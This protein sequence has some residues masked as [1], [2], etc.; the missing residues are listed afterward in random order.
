MKSHYRAVIIG[1]GVI[2]ASVAY[3]LTKLG[4]TDIA[5][6]ERSVLT[7]GSSWHAA[8]GVHTLNADPNVAALQSYTIDLMHEIEKESGQSVGLHM[9]G[10]LMLARAPD[11]WEWLQSNCRVLQSMGIDDAW[12]ATPDEL[13]AQ[14]SLLNTSDLLG[15]MVFANEGYVDPSG[16]VHAYAKCAKNRGAD[17]IEHNRVLSLRQRPDMSWEVTTEKGVIIA[18]HVVNAGGL[19]AKQ[20]GRMV[21]VELPVSPME[22]HYLV[23]ESIPEI[24]ALS[25]EIPTIVDLDGFSY[26]RQ[27]QKGMLLGIYEINHKHWNMDGAPWDYGIELI[28]EDTDR[29]SDELAMA[30]HRYPC[31]ET[32]GIKRWVNGAFTFSPDGNPLVGPVR[33]VP[34]YWVACG[35]MAGFVQGGGVGK[36]LAE[37]MVSGETEVD[38]FGMDIARYGDFAGNKEFIR[39]TTGQF[40]SRRFIMTYPNEHLPAG[41]PVRTPGAYDAMT[42]AG[43]QWTALYGLE[44]PLYFAPK[45]FKETLTLKRSNATPIIANEVKAVRERAGLLDISAFS[46]YEVSGPKASEWLDHILACHLPKPGRARLAPMLGPDGR[47]KGDLTV[48]N[49]GD[50]TWWIMGS[51]YL[52]EWHM[53]WFEDHMAEGVNLRDVSDIVTGFGLVGP[54]SREIL[55]KVT[56]T[57]LGSMKLLGCRRMD[58]GLHRTQVA[59]MSYTGEMGF[60]ISCGALEH[61]ALRRLLLSAGAE[62]G[63]TEFGFAAGNSLR[64]EKSVGIW[65][66]EFTQGYTPGMTGFDRFVAYDKGDFIGAEAVRAE[67][68]GPGSAKVLV[69]LEVDATDADASGYEPV[70]HKGKLVGFVTSGGYGHTIGRSLAMA[71][72][73]RAVAAPG[74]ELSVHIVAQ[75]RGARVIPASPYDPDGKVMRA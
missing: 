53:R 65:S 45:G 1:G 49:W 50:G 24:A 19:W 25:K 27:E 57:D 63:L 10:G 73:D 67:R 56:D 38:V 29:I 58:V 41:R 39:Q 23:T 28:Q 61:S 59:R 17:I 54:K 48:M 55:Q 70:W 40:Y 30:F 36:S 33:G 47:L 62:F 16:V 15:G 37:W 9:T 32:T 12:I 74:T 64:L 26:M 71:M 21:G 52:R 72:V 35:V 66:R 11:R 13:K 51:Y 31:L 69:T 60:E 43:A 6:L 20:L 7:A 68:D 75:E 18:E 2:G 14:C 46:R 5:I 34:N 42:E 44:A 4:W 8:G 22:H 3:H